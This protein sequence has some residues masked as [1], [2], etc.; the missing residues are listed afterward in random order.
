VGNNLFLNKHQGHRTKHRTE[1]NNNNN[2][3]KIIA[4]KNRTINE[5]LS[6]KSLTVI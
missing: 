6:I 2:N 1:N 4:M 3:N 5:E